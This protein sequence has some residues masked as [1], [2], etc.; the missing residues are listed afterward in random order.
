MK[1]LVKCVDTS[2]VESLRL[3]ARYTAIDDGDGRDVYDILNFD[4]KGHDGEYRKDRFIIIKKILDYGFTGKC[5]SNKNYEDNF[6][7]GIVYPVFALK[8]GNIDVEDANGVMRIC[9]DVMFE[10][11]IL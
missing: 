9:Q 2:G 7:L 5:L 10:I 1:Y 3:G 4:G 8:P 11:T 6:E